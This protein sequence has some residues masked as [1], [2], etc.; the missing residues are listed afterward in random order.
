MPGAAAVLHTR[1]VDFSGSNWNVGIVNHN[2]LHRIAVLVCGS[3][4]LG[5]ST[6]LETISKL[7][8]SQ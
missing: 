8:S 3:Q 5:P 1:S 4:L 6:G 7:Y 2:I